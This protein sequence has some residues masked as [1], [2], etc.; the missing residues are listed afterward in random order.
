MHEVV[1]YEVACAYAD[2]YHQALV[3]VAERSD[4]LDASWRPRQRR[5]PEQVI[6]ERVA[7]MR[8]HA[9]QPGWPG[10][11]NGGVL[12][13]ADWAPDTTALRAEADR[14]LAIADQYEPLPCT[15][16]QPR[17]PV[18]CRCAGVATYAKGGHLGRV[19]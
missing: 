5:D 8:R 12:P 1:E 4:A 13:G 16:C 10:L 6:R 3:D 14:W 17:Y 19:A 2:G 11:D 9:A 7:E 18:L 15:R